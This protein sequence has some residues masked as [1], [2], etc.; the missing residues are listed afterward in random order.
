MYYNA[1]K[2]ISMC[3]R[4]FMGDFVPGASETTFKSK[5]KGR[6]NFCPNCLPFYL[7]PFK[8]AVL[9]LFSLGIEISDNNSS[10]ISN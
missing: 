3:N 6:P 1:G 8:N 10:K 5:S 2:K 7:K 4:R 9:D